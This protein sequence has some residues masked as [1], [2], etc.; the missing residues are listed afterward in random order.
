MPSWNRSQNPPDVLPPSIIMG[1][2]IACAL[3]LVTNLFGI[4]WGINPVDA[5]PALQQVRGE[6]IVTLLSW[7][8]ACTGVVTAVSA[9]SMFRLRGDVTT[10]ILGTALLFCGLMDAANAL[11]INGILVSASDP[12]RF[13]DF[14]DAMTRLT[15]AMIITLG[16]APFA[17]GFITPEWSGS[18]NNRNAGFLIC[19][20]IVFGL[21]AFSIVELCAWIPELP[22]TVFPASSIP[23][24]LD[25]FTLIIYLITGIFFLPRFYKQYPSLFSH[26]LLLSVI[27]HILL[28]MYM[29]FG[30]RRFDDNA[31]VIAHYL[32]IVGYLVPFIGLLC[33]Y[34][35]V[36][37]V[38]AKM[39]STEAQLQLARQL[40]QA[41]LPREAP[42]I[43]NY[44]LAGFSIPAEAVGGDYFDYLVYGDGS[45]G[46]V[47]ADVS[48]HDLGASI[49]MSQTRAFLRADLSV[50]HD[51]AIIA[52]RLNRFLCDGD[53][54]GHRFVS[55][56]FARLIPEQHELRYI[57]AGQPGVVL[58]PDGG[59]QA[60]SPTGPVLGFDPHCQ[61]VQEQTKLPPGSLLLLYT[62]GITETTDTSGLALGT[63]PLYELLHAGQGQSAEHLTSVI[64]TAV[65]RHAGERGPVDDL[66][67][68]LLKRSQQ[69]A[70]LPLNI[71]ASLAHATKG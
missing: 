36:S 22:K 60:L 59:T 47:I 44:Q 33:D 71:G 11:A 35:R 48:G 17:L 15:Y 30:S 3:P 56:F 14:T 5:G 63:Q 7:T 68:L 66:T 20:A 51:P 38:E 40:Q 28:Q 12:S 62:D 6:I 39:L 64:K 43:T 52:E 23:R 42:V 4:R 53:I 16:T 37:Q 9:F 58:F 31:A 61:F 49:L 65:L 18:R 50:G 57:A 46:L 32:K 24:P 55:L 25:A 34:S 70:N 29:A 41:L 2:V 67:C 45:I 1:L 21:G 10:P 69:E 8:A 13:A 19:A 26:G 27:P 54:L